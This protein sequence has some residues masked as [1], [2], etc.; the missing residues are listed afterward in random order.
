[1]V[2]NVV[3]SDAIDMRS[4]AGDALYVTHLSYIFVT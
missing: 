2:G 4:S 3:D 1:M